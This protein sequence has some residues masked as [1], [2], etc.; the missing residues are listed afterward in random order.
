M[1]G[2]KVATCPKFDVYSLGIIAFE[3]LYKFK[4]KRERGDVLKELRRGLFPNDFGN[5]MLREGIGHMICKDRVNRWD[6]AAVRRW[7]M[8]I[9]KAFD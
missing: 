7:L 3:L 4:T 6:C 2:N 5:H 1:R 8:D 9:K